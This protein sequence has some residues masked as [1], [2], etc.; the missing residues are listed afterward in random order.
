ME[1]CQQIQIA[2]EASVEKFRFRQ[3]KLDPIQPSM[4]SNWRQI[5]FEGPQATQTT[6]KPTFSTDAN[7][8][9]TH[10]DLLDVSKPE[11]SFVAEVPLVMPKKRHVHPQKVHKPVKK[12]FDDP[13]EL[14]AVV[15]R[16]SPTLRHTNAYIN[17]G[18][19]LVVRLIDSK[20]IVEA[21]ADTPLNQARLPIYI[22]TLRIVRM[23]RQVAMGIRLA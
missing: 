19:D 1:Q 7:Q 5:I 12:L 20:E 16:W 15:N 2:M 22:W 8:R 11:E 4:K 17:D 14:Y 10:A 21:L 18:G 23:A 9:T 6:Q 13:E 3:S